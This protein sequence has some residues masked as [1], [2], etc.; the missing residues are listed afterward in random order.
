MPDY[1]G[2]EKFIFD[3]ISGELPDH[4]TYHGVHHT[5]DVL[6]A[7]MRIAEAEKLGMEDVKLLRVAVFLHDA[8]FIQVYK[9]HEEIGCNMAREM[10]PSFGFT[11]EMIRQVC[12]M[13]MATKLPQ[14]PLTAAER[15]IADADLDY[16]GRNDFYSI[17]STLFSEFKIYLGIKDE[18]E[19]N[20]VQINFL[21]AHR[22]HTAYAQ[23]QRAPE[24]EKRLRELEA[25]VN[26]YSL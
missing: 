26:S 3:K 1:T 24:K 15:V 21:R 6:E 8:G 23:Q 10:L 16:L 17:G 2:S 5:L 9:G 12:G 4:L 11:D 13:I 19:W 20:R 14:Q 22:Y 25:I 18:E 7:A